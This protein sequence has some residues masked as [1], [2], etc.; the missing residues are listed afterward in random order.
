MPKASATNHS[1]SILNENYG[2]S[3]ASDYANAIV[4]VERHRARDDEGSSRNGPNKR[5]TNIRQHTANADPPG[6]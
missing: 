5:Q 1:A 4:K 2:L 6:A 3:E